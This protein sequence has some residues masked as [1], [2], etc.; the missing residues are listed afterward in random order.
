ML[1]KAISIAVEAHFGQRDKAGLPYILHPLRLMNKSQ[2][3]SEKICSILHDVVEDTTITISSLKN[4]EF[5]AYI[6]E[7]LDCLTKRKGEEYQKFIERIKKN[8]LAVKI[9]ILDI[10]DNLNA[11]RLQKVENKDVLRINKYIVALSELR[12]WNDT[13]V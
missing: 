1:E 5:D 6:L 9:K 8:K 2:T 10:E 11:A 7:A 3:V 4:E 13:D 12:E